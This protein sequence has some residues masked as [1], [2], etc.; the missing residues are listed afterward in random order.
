MRCMRLEQNGTPLSP[1]NQMLTW[2][3]R[4]DGYG[5]KNLAIEQVQRV[6]FRPRS[7]SSGSTRSPVCRRCL[8]RIQNFR[9]LQRQ[10]SNHNDINPF[11]AYLH[12]IIFIIMIGP[13]FNSITCFTLSFEPRCAVIFQV[14]M[15]LTQISHLLCAPVGSVT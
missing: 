2:P 6:S 15:C 1:P 14:S 3:R 5:T 8:R 7:I 9:R 13:Y 10:V 12:V 4:L 11:L